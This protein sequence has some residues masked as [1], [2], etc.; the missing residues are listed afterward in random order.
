MWLG[1]SDWKRC[2]ACADWGPALVLSVGEAVSRGVI[3]L[4]CPA[5]HVWAH[6]LDD[7]DR[8][9]LH[10]PSPPPSPCWG[11]CRGPD[12]EHWTFAAPVPSYT[13]ARRVLARWRREHPP[14]W[15]AITCD[16]VADVMVRPKGA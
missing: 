5:G 10:P 15:L 11:V 6:E 2:A 14:E 12:F 9:H 13:V 7:I 1:E 3:T 16:G 8:L 4:R